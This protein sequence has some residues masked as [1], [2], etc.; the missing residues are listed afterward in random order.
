LERE[1]KEL[2]RIQQ[3]QRVLPVDMLQVRETLVNANIFTQ[4][5]I[6]FQDDLLRVAASCFER[7]G[8]FVELG[9]FRGGLSAQLC[10]LAAHFERKTIIC[11]INESYLQ[12]AFRA[13]ALVGAMSGAEYFHGTL[14]DLAL[15]VCAK[16]VI[17]VFIDGDHRYE[18]VAADIRSLGAFSSSPRIVAFHDF[19]LRSTQPELG[20]VRVD[21]AVRDAF[22]G[23]AIFRPMG[24]V[25]GLGALPTDP[26]DDG[27]Y[28]EAGF[29]EGVWCE[30]R[31]RH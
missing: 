15:S 18:A 20:S 12:E 26:S 29:P 25:A 24:Q 27:T 1:R 13:V 31:L 14:S 23:N 8:D 21:L 10:Y 22:K 6:E 3:L 11:D 5:S 2:L 30:L 17:G 28:C 4:T 19:S 16:D 7:G 9:C